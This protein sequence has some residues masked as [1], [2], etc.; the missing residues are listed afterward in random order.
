MVLQRLLLALINR[1][2]LVERLAESKAIRRAAQLTAFAVIKGRLAG[3]Q[4]SARLRDSDTAR[5]MRE[6]AR[7]MPQSAADAAQTVS[8]IRNTFMKEVKE[9]MREANRQIKDRK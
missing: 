6:E 7:R 2:Q 8:R 9:G 4:A 1:A 3:K 5:M